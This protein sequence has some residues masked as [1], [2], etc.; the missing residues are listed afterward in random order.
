[1]RPFCLALVTGFVLLSGAQTAGAAVIRVSPGPG[2]PLQDAIDA[3]AAGDVLRVEAGTYD[4]A[5][6][7]DKRLRIVGS[8][9]G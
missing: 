6:V 1:M 2:T 3:A 7:I 8:R 4:E 9:S 5:I